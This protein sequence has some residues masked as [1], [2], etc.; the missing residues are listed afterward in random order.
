MAQGH[1]NAMA[2]VIRHLSAERSPACLIDAGGLFLFVNEAWDQ[3]PESHSPATTLVGTSW[4]DGFQ[5]EEIRR[6]HAE[7]L[8]KALRPPPGVRPRP[9]TH[10][11]EKNTPT[12]AVLVKIRMEPVVMEGGPVAV[13]ITH[14]AVRERPID[15]VYEPVERPADDFRDAAGA[16]TQCSCC[17]RFKD[18]REEDRWDLVPALVEQVPAGTVRSLCGMCRELHYNQPPA[19]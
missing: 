10:V 1:H 4:L 19:E 6:L 14:T 2:D 17:G 5:G 3:G 8:F 15:E 12:S 11:V 7:L 9:V 16:V 13:A 18:P